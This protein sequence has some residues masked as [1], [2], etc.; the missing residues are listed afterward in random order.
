MADLPSDLV[1]EIFFCLPVQSLLRF[2]SISKSLKSLIDS[3]NF[4]NLHLKNSLDFNL[5]LRCNSNLYQLDFPNLTVTIPLNHPFTRYDTN[6]SL[7]NSY[8]GLLCI[9]N[10]IKEIAFWNPNIRSKYC[11]LPYLPI[12]SDFE[13]HI[14]ILFDGHG[15][16]FDSFTG[17]YKFVKISCVLDPQ[18]HTYHSQVRIFSWKTYSWKV[19]SRTTDIIVSIQ[20]MG[21]LVE[22][23]LHWVDTSPR[24]FAF[25]ITQEVFNEVPLL[26]IMVANNQIS[27]IYVSLLGVFVSL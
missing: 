25:N 21:V 27:T 8:N 5:I 1:T 19:F 4:T 22:N 3:H 12:T 18:H 24:C 15:C 26:E 7:L 14:I 20:T 13:D 10:D 17:D 6:I 9:S 2:R 16:I 11:I 23:S